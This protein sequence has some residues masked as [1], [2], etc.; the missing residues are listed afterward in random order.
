[1]TRGRPIHLMAMAA[2]LSGT[3]A[4]RA[5]MLM[6]RCPMASMAVESLYEIDFAAKTVRLTNLV[7]PI[8]MVATVDDR[9]VAWRS[10]N[11]SFRLDRAS[12]EL[13]QANSPDGPW[14]ITA[15]CVPM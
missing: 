9:F 3:Q 11:G 6:L 15:F 5:E 7:S 13:M 1:V 12:R 8:T 10:S 4:A 14:E 2:A